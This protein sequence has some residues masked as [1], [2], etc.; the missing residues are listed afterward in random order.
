[1]L[2]A[3][4]Q[5]KPDVL[6]TGDVKYHDAR[7]LEASGIFTIDAGHFGTEAFFAGNLAERLSKQFPQ[8]HIKTE[9]AT[10]VYHSK[11]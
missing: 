8:I 11:S 4:Q 1:M 7:E 9:Y 6:I 10:D 3:L 5:D 2:N